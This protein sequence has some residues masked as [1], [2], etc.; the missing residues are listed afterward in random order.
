MPWSSKSAGRI[1]D[2]RVAQAALFRVRDGRW[3]RKADCPPFERQ[4]QREQ[5]RADLKTAV[6][7]LTPII[8]EHVKGCVAADREVEA[9]KAEDGRSGGHGYFAPSARIGE[10]VTPKH[11]MAGELETFKSEVRDAIN[12]APTS[13]VA[14]E[15]V[16]AL[17]AKEGVLAAFRAKR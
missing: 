11:D 13:Q 8:E 6:E 1:Q 15:R 7:I 9:A 17:L 10:S 14:R 12:T 2:L 4:R 5:D 16:A 3:A